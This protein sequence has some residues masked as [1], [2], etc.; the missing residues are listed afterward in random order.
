MKRALLAGGA[1]DTGIGIPTDDDYSFDRYKSG[2]YRAKLNCADALLDYNLDA[3]KRIEKP[4]K[5]ELKDKVSEIDMYF[6]VSADNFEDSEKVLLDT[7]DGE[8]EV[9][10]KYI[11]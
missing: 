6:I 10:Y 1:I 9:Y 4:F 7:Q 11:N 3:A 5:K 8:I 2:T